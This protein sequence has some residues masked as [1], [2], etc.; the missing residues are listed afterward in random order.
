MV[1]VRFLDRIAQVVIAVYAFTDPREALAIDFADT[2]RG[3]AILDS[4]NS[5]L[6]FVEQGEPGIRDS[7]D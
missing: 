7:C 3:L 5:G 1:V 4:M 2:A 6:H